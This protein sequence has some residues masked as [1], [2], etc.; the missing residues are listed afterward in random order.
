MGE[1]HVSLATVGHTLAEFATQIVILIGHWIDWLFT[2]HMLLGNVVSAALLLGLADFSIQILETIVLGTRTRF[3]GARNYR[4]MQVG[5]VLGVFNHIWYSFLDS[6]LEGGSLTVVFKK[7]ALDQAIAGPFFSSAYLVG[8]GLLEGKSTEEVYKEWSQKFIHIYM[9]DWMF[10]PLAQ[11]INFYLVPHRFRVFYVNFATFLWNTFLCCAKHNSE[12]EMNKRQTGNPDQNSSGVI[13]HRIPE[14]GIELNNSPEGSRCSLSPSKSTCRSLKVTRRKNSC[15]KP[16]KLKRKMAKSK[17]IYK[18]PLSSETQVLSDVKQHSLPAE[19]RSSTI[20]S[21]V[22]VKQLL[23]AIELPPHNN[24][25]LIRVKDMRQDSWT[26]ENCTN[27][28]LSLTGCSST[29]SS[30]SN[31]RVASAKRITSICLPNRSLCLPEKSV[32]TQNKKMPKRKNIAAFTATN[33]T[34]KPQVHNIASGRKHDT[35]RAPPNFRRDIS[36]TVKPGNCI[37]EG[38]DVTKKS[39]TPQYKAAV[40]PVTKSF[41]RNSVL[42]PASTIRVP[43]SQEE[44]RTALKDLQGLVLKGQ[45][46]AR[47]G[48]AE[49]KAQVKCLQE[50]CAVTYVSVDDGT[51]DLALKAD[52][53][54]AWVQMERKLDINNIR[55][56]ME[57][58]L[59]TKSP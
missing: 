47:E 38:G 44:I 43:Q 7:I 17:H 30:S 16:V 34:E 39:W 51:R 20:N 29:S 31:T 28:S 24:G 22:S 11:F 55:T 36:S 53:L 48:L 32:S 57:E 6:Y 52:Q 40:T 25:S 8:M 18:R 19:G 9:V 5:M 12:T 15:R 10:W 4:S 45:K 49:T 1:S 13:Y 58:V 2:E 41:R 23:P 56:M 50:L 42:K 27:Y 35:I 26:T 3:D 33:A 46:E 14:G 21:I 59:A 54:A 37:V